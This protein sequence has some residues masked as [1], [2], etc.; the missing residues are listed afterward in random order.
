MDSRLRST[1][2]QIRKYLERLLKKKDDYYSK[3]FIEHAIISLHIDKPSTDDESYHYDSAI[4][5]KIYELSHVLGIKGYGLTIITYLLSNDYLEVGKLVRESKIPRTQV[6]H[7]MD[8]LT[9]KGMVMSTIGRPKQFY[10]VNKET[11]FAPLANHIQ[12]KLDTLNQFTT[13]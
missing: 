2:I 6:Y 4:A 12:E 5:A 10:I 1:K 9:N 8:K 7:V 13:N 3:K 11:P